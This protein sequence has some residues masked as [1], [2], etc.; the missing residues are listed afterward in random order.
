M[1]KLSSSDPGSSLLPSFNLLL[2]SNRFKY[3]YFVQLKNSQL[4]IFNIKNLFLI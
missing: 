4:S 3:F 2:I 1:A